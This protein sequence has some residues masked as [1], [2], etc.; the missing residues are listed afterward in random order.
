MS[1]EEEETRLT[2]YKFRSIIRVPTSLLKYRTIKLPTWEEIQ[3]KLNRP[4][5]SEA[6]WQKRKEI[7]ELSG[8]VDDP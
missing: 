5:P 8:W 1:D 2:A 7:E 4:P 6:E 3:E